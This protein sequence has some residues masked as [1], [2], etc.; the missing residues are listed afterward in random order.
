M[1]TIQAAQD[2][3]VRR[4][5]QALTNYIDQP[6]SSDAKTVR[7]VARNEF[8]ALFAQRCK[9]ARGSMEVAEVASRMGVH[10]NTIWN[11]ERGETM[12]DAF[13]LQ[14]MAHLYGTTTDALIGL[15][16][17]G[18]EESP[19]PAVPKSVRAIEMGDY[20]YVPHFDLQVSAGPG[21]FQDLESVVT[22]RPFEAGYIRRELGI[23]HAEMAMCGVTGRSALP[24]LKPKDTVLVDLRDRSVATEGMHVIRLDDALML[25]QVQRLPGRVLRVSSKNEEYQSF[26]IEANEES[27]RDFEV[28]GRVRWGGVTFY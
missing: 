7:D 19:N 17:H 22:M 11:I 24:D 8:R 12:P 27:Q 25:K 20:I 13:E 28:I 10:R 21:A 6:L 23:Q 26:E 15:H 14:L 5:E 4:V 1:N 3:D 18:H 9:A 2:V 16:A